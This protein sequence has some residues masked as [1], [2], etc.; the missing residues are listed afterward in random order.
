[1]LEYDLSLPREQGGIK[2]GWHK[3][4]A[5]NYW[6]QFWKNKDGDIINVN[7]V[8][9]ANQKHSKVTIFFIRN[10]QAISMLEGAKKILLDGPNFY[11]P[12]TINR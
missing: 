5:G 2:G 3:S 12:I 6:T 10:T 11:Q 7:I 4:N 9:S 1:M 8:A